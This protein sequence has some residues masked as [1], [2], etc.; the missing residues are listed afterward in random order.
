VVAKEEPRDN[1][2]L[3]DVENDFNDLSFVDIDFPSGSLE[4]AGVLEKNVETSVLEQELK[5]R[6]ES[7]TKEVAT[8]QKVEE[9]V[10]ASIEDTKKP[11]MKAQP[12][13][14]LIDL[15]GPS[16][17]TINPIIQ[18]KIVYPDLE[19]LKILNDQ[20]N[21]PKLATKEKETLKP[22]TETQMQ[23]LYSNNQ[24]KLIESFENEFIS[25]ELRENQ[26]QVDHALYRLLK[27][28]AVSRA[29]LKVNLSTLNKLKKDCGDFCKNVWS[30]EKKVVYTSGRCSKEHSVGVS[31]QYE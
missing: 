14:P 4:S 12:S 2:F 21:V 25:R 28:Y 29:D 11:E 10:P 6:E 18:E 13:A 20:L 27:R 19:N 5:A 1:S 8:D 30:L 3:E 7:E 9:Q 22:F 24:L 17:I 31:C 16:T 15:P 26:K 23:Q